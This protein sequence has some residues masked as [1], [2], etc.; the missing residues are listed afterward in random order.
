MLASM[1]AIEA[2]VRPVA[3]GRLRLV[4]LFVNTLDVEPRK[5][6]LDTPAALRAWLAE[7]DLAAART[8]VS[9]A[10]LEL[11]RELREALRALLLANNGADLDAGAL[12]VLNRVGDQAGLR[13]SFD[14]EGSPHL[15]PGTR[16]VLGAMG[17]LVAAVFVSMTDGT[18][19]NL[20]ACAEETCTWAFYD[21]SRNHSRTW[22]DM[23]VCGNRVK[24]RAFRRRQG[25]KP[26]GRR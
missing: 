18:F 8:S 5:E 25:E 1:S 19:P 14:A 15:H 24:V 2:P 13:I 12:A 10:D 6:M 17:F 7:Q 4:Q 16:G 3:P 26:A 11:A 9:A 21:S 23:A 22:C 20:K